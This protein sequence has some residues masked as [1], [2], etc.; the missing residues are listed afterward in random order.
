RCFWTDACANKIL[1]NY[2]RFSVSTHCAV[3][4]NTWSVSLLGVQCGI[5]VQEEILE[6]SLGVLCIV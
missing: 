2:V 4:E 6:A 3:L 5:W 1:W